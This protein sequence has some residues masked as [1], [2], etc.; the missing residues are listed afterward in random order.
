MDK[1]KQIIISH[2]HGNA[3][4][5][6]A[7]YGIS[8]KGMLFRYV[9]SIAVFSSGGWHR[10][11][12]LPGLGMFMRK[13]YDDS[14]QKKT[15]CYPLKE[16]GRQICGKLKIKSL[17]KHETGVFCTDKESEYIDKKT[18]HTVIKAKGDV[19]AVYCYED[20]AL[21]TFREAKSLDKVCLYDLPTGYWKAKPELLNA[22]KNKNPEWAMTITGLIDSPEKL[23]RKDE[24]LRLAD[25]ISV[26]SS[27][28]RKTLEYAPFPL[29]NV[30][31]IPYGFPPVNKDRIYEP[32]Q[33]RKIKVLYVGGLTQQ[34]GLSYMFEALEGLYDK[35]EVTI[36]GRGNL[37]GC[38]ALRTALKNVNYIPS[39]PHDEVLKLMTKQDLFIFP[40]LFDGFGMVV[41]EAMSQ[42]TP[43]IA[44]DRSCGP[45]IIT[46]G[47]N[48]WVV[49][50]GT[51]TPIRQL[52][53]EFIAN[54]TILMKVGMAAMKTAEQ[55]PWTKYEDELA[56]SVCK[57]LTEKSI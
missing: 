51:A 55:R 52:L 45:D 50:A 54:P 28:T 38:A 24:E 27:F 16:L 22:E 2:P 4:T 33:G 9:T 41:T 40:S 30:K 32:I 17:I 35:I 14:I 11:A 34:K 7:I 57:F 3:N 1:Q 23:A 20:V 44:T 37:D 31:V 6:S 46:H 36:V 15:V 53:E 49:E 12:Q 21:H 10:L 25:V 39:L 19:D 47:K 8:R 18:A 26:A 56:E 42:G 29:K 5:R 13:T 43:V 48:G